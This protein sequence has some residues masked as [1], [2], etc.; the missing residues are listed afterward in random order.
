MRLLKYFIIKAEKDIDGNTNV[1][2]DMMTMI[3]NEDQENSNKDW[4]TNLV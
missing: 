1:I 4:T 3:E 2:S